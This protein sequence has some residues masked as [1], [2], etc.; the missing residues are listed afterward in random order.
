LFLPDG[1]LFGGAHA[2][3]RLLALI[4]R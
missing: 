4:P 2:V 1:K 3:F